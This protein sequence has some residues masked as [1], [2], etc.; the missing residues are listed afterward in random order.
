MRSKWTAE[1]DKKLMDAVKLFGE[2][3]WQQIA[4]QL[5]E[6]TGQ[7]CLHRWM[8]T[9]N[10]A[11]KRGRW[12]TDEDKRLIMAVHAYPLNNWVLVQRHTQGRTDVQCRERWCNILN[13]EL[14]T[15]P[16]SKEEDE[17]LKKAI[18]EVGAGNWSKIAEIM[19][20]R[21]D[22]QCWRRWRLISSEE[23]SNY[24]KKINTKKKALVKNFVGREKERPEITA[25]DFEVPEMDNDDNEDILTTLEDLK[26]KP[27]TL[28]LR[29]E[30]TFLSLSVFQRA[31]DTL[32]NAQKEGRLKPVVEI[33]CQRLDQ[34]R[35]LI[36]KAP[37]F[38]GV[39]PSNLVRRVSTLLH[40]L[41]LT[42]IPR[43][44]TITNAS[45][46][47]EFQNSIPQ[48]LQSQPLFTTPCII[49]T[50]LA[51]SL[52]CIPSSEVS[53]NALSML[54]DIL[55][56]RPPPKKTPTTIRVVDDATHEEKSVTVPL[57]IF[58]QNSKDFVYDAPTVTL[59]DSSILQ[60][61]EFKA[62]SAVFNSLFQK[63]MQQAMGKVAERLP[64]LLRRVPNI[65]RLNEFVNESQNTYLTECQS[66]KDSLVI[67]KSKWNTDVTLKDPPTFAPM[68]SLYQHVP[69]DEVFEKGPSTEISAPFILVKQKG[70]RGRPKGSK[71]K[72]TLELEKQKS[73]ASQSTQP[74]TQLVDQPVKR[75]RGRPKGSKNKPKTIE[76]L[77]EQKK[78]Q[79]NK[80]VVRKVSKN[81]V[82]SA[83]KKRKLSKSTEEENDEE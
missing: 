6:R 41:R 46:V 23:V 15:G 59:N 73:G 20:P 18:K 76:Q 11:I 22:N 24:R 72:K 21:T 78:K 54:Q 55:Y 62:L 69:C 67:E 79:L 61:G 8:K 19:Y 2:K 16:W 37:Y 47:Q 83:S 77:T 51:P 48:S 74:E 32:I 7:Q 52:P 10:P 14:N 28:A 71:N 80:P 36:E 57:P 33:E 82:S 26:N 64:F 4:N 75:G 43:S 44:L 68:F 66:T 31:I 5:E 49:S 27:R 3:S 34:I 81:A 56:T 29:D 60:T 42:Q 39:P 50:D 17:S 58:Q 38:I 65:D 25:D 45:T 9:L 1:E 63:P 35:F 53:L 70:L 40:T 13:P 30:Q 12:S